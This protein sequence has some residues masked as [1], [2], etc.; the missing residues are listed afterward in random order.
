MS[1]GTRFDEWV[2]NMINRFMC[3]HGL[4]GSYGWGWLESLE[5]TMRT[6]ERE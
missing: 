3:K 4:Y 5:H 2:A 6:M 1:Y